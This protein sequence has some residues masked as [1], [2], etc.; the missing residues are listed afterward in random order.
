MADD[1]TKGE[2]GNPASLS[3]EGLASTTL[4]A[5]ANLIPHP[6]GRIVATITAAPLGVAVGRYISWKIQQRKREE[7]RR[8]VNEEIDDVRK[9]LA[10]T[11]LSPERREKLND[12]LEGLRQVRLKHLLLD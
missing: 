1:I 9:E 5:L 3:Y 6:T 12:E 2:A 8:I 4:V 7:A 10:R 11:D